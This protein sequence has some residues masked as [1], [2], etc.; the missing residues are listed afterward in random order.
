MLLGLLALGGAT[1]IICLGKSI[2]VLAIGRVLQGI[3]A[4][5]PW[6]VGLS[7][8]VDTVGP[9]GVGQAMGYVGLS[10]SMAM[11][12]APLLGGVVFAE[13]RNLGRTSP[14]RFLIC[15]NGVEVVCPDFASGAISCSAKI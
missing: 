4:S 8:L 6:V 7:L 14:C 13:V 11:L 3:S 1:V 5:V 9:D 12:V 15:L 2:A 10:M